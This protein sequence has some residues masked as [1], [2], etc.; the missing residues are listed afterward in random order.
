[1][2]VLLVGCHFGR[3]EE[4]DALLE[5]ALI[6]SG[7]EVKT[8][9]YLAS[10]VRVPLVHSLVPARIRSLLSPRRIAAVAQHDAQASNVRFVEAVRHF[11]PD[12]VL[13][14]RAE[15]L[16]A[17]ALAVARKQAVLL[18]W[19]SDEPWRFNPSETVECFDLWAVTDRTWETW[20][21]ERGASRVEYLALAC[22]PK[23]HAP[24]ELSADEKTKWRSEICFVGSYLPLRENYL[25]SVADLGLAVWGPGW[26][27]VQDAAL[28][29][30]VRSSRPLA[31]KDWL[32]AYAAAKVVV[33]I[34][35]QGVEGL[36]LRIWEALA[37]QT[38]LVTDYRIDFERLLPGQGA[39]FR[40][41]AELKSI[42]QAL[43]ADEPR[44][45]KLARAGRE[46]VLNGHTFL[47]RAKTLVAWME[48]IRRERPTRE[49][50]LDG[51]G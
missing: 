50:P 24:V 2:R 18:N 15:R 46:A 25:K 1:M 47:H 20:L 7:C 49:K 22:D 42:C 37:A 35:G 13:A 38:C 12:A 4:T 44:R 41:A 6:E 48:A 34:Q 29:R 10:A 9:D 19:T 3:V 14:L 28:R 33:N 51:P 30:C 31:R 27:Q 39:S 40:S 26:D 8:F 32:K 16:D 45:L 5:R 11:Q 17:A 43:L 21:A 23:L 36:S